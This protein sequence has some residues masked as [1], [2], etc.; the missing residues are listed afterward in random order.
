[1]NFITKFEQG[2]RGENKGL[3]IGE[4]LKHLDKT[5]NG[6]QKGRIYAIA[7][8]PK[9]GKSTL[10]NFAFVINPYL[11]S[12]ANNIDIQWLYLSYEID[13]V[14]QEF[15]FAVYFLNHDFGITHV[16]L[17]N[18]TYTQN[19]LTSNT[20]EISPDYLKGILLGDDNEIIKV[21]PRILT[22]LKQVY[23]ERI[24]PLFGEYNQYGQKIRSGK[25]EI[26]THKEN[27]T[28][29]YNFLID[30]AKQNG[31]FITRNFNGKER[32]ISYI[33][34]NP[35]KYTI[36]IIDH[37]RKLIPERGYNMKQIV[38]KMSEY[39]VEIRDLCGFTFV[40]IIHT[41][42]SIT[43]PERLK[44]AKDMLYPTSEDLKD[45]GNLAEDCNYLIT[46][47]N[48]NDERY[49]LQ[50]HFGLPIRDSFGNR[51]Y[52]NLRTLH[53]VESRHCVYPQHFRVNM[54]GNLKK[55]EQ[56]IE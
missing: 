54:F 50:K 25:M 51:L 36:I 9:Q 6:I 13:R 47:F 56:I 29:I 33:P 12:V 49:K 16:M 18:Q 20:I 7:S 1:M 10:A 46:M 15:D 22:A 28:G 26:L 39:I 4:G 44:A 34:N 32:L 24:I 52:P 5:L 8:A 48:P 27:P 23:K 11:Y 21:K 19:G 17:E 14:S 45:T 35:Q 42:R 41:N 2:Q 43:D 30:Y 55:F 53:L 31:S 37:M 3:S 38:D 40:P